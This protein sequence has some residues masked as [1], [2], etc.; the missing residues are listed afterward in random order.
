MP[1]PTCKACV[2]CNRTCRQP[3]CPAAQ[4]FERGSDAPATTP[5]WGANPVLSWGT[6]KIPWARHM[7]EPQRCH[8]T[9]TGHTRSYLHRGVL[10]HAACSILWNWQTVIF[11]KIFQISA[12][13]WTQSMIRLWRAVVL[14]HLS[15]SW[16][17][18]FQDV[19][20]TWLPAVFEKPLCMRDVVMRA[21]RPLH[22]AKPTLSSLWRHLISPRFCFLH[23]TFPSNSS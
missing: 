16:S 17:G 19:L 14:G 3:M 9:P 7:C 12:G 2:L 4:E 5:L 22:W 18:L 15:A 10:P 8:R 13:R 21:S 11:P 20:T 6:S 1:V 23:F